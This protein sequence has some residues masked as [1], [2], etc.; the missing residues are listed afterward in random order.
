MKKSPKPQ[1][2]QKAQTS[3]KKEMIR[4]KS[5]LSTS[6]NEYTMV[7]KPKTDLTPK[8]KT[9]LKF[10]S[11]SR[12]PQTSPLASC[13]RLPIFVYL[14]NVQGDCA[15]TNIDFWTQSKER[16]ETL[17]S[18]VTGS[19][20]DILNTKPVCVHDDTDALSSTYQVWSRSASTAITSDSFWQSI[21]PDGRCI[22]LI[23]DE[24]DALG[25]H[26]GMEYAHMHVQHGTSVG[27][28]FS[29]YLKEGK[30]LLEPYRQDTVPHNVAAIQKSDAYQEKSSMYW[31]KSSL[32]YSKQPPLLLSRCESDALSSTN[33]FQVLNAAIEKLKILQCEEEGVS[34]C[35]S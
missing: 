13:T 23:S 31:M 29:V 24:L 4:L 20:S 7:S 15:I 17:F 32:S 11:G 10:F 19:K 27:N 26:V 9:D 28:I 12:A 2:A 22:T 18:W 35:I 34:C 6:K 33:V 1:K 14:H 30:V 3:P 8:F 25:E 21:S 5:I 16:E